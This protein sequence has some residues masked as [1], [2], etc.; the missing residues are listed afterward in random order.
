MADRFSVHS[1]LRHVRL[2]AGYLALGV[3]LAAFAMAAYYGVAASRLEDKRRFASHRW[4]AYFF[5][6]RYP[7]NF[8][9]TGYRLHTRQLVALAVALLALVVAALVAP[10]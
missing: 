9:G 8:V 5:P 7:E 3:A 2:L 4:L 1:P 6:S 10:R